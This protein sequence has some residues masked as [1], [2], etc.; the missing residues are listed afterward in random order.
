[1]DAMLRD[2]K[3]INPA[4]VVFQE[5]PREDPKHLVKALKKMG[6]TDVRLDINKIRDRLV[7]CGNLVAAKPGLRMQHIKT[8]YPSAKR[9]AIAVSVHWKGY[10]IAV[11]GTHLH[12]HYQESHIR[13]Q[14]AE[15]IMDWVDKE[16]R[17]RYL[18]YL[19]LGDM[20]ETW[21]KPGVQV[22]A[23]RG[24]IEVFR[25]LRRAYPQMTCWRGSEID[26]IFSSAPLM[27][28]CIGAFLRHSVQSDH[29]PVLADFDIPDR[30]KAQKRQK[31]VAKAP[32]KVINLAA[33]KKRHYSSSSSGSSSD[34][35]E[36]RGKKKK[37]TRPT[38]QK[39]K[40]RQEKGRRSTKVNSARRA[41]LAKSSERKRQQSSERSEGKRDQRPTISS[42]E[43]QRERRMLVGLDRASSMK[44]SKRR[45]AETWG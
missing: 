25:G 34:T 1:L 9:N 36:D 18:Y 33:A 17:Q 37:E 12:D 39:R 26:F 20:N 41:S 21:G 40:Q 2:V 35:S 8:L 23:D 7:F 15:A 6:Y 22:F 14:E 13:K 3:A 30:F 24:M 44:T 32:S 28:R 5:V 16:V 19:I 11:I 38:Q 45:P 31:L 29:M 42:S 27:Q 43:K 4:V 10:D